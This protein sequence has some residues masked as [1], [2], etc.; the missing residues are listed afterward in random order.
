VSCSD[1]LAIDINNFVPDA[2]SKTRTVRNGV[3]VDFVCSEC[4]DVTRPDDST[5]R[6]PYVLNVGTFEHKKGQDVLVDA[7]ARVAP[8]FPEVDLIIVGR[9]GATR[10]ALLARIKELGLEGRVF[11][12]VDVPHKQTLRFMRDAMVFVLPS[13]AEGLPIAILEAGAL[14][15]PVIASRV[16]GIPEVIDTQDR[17][18]LVA[19]EDGN[20]L[21]EALRTLIKSE[22]LRMRLGHAL[23][24]HVRLNF[25]WRSAWQRYAALLGSAGRLRDPGSTLASPVGRRR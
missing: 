17:G 11:C 6:R 12:R 23:H 2:R 5:I 13:R 25:S 16:D 18:W 7:F 15:I 24:D 10:A 22:G 9:D 20:G 3:D 4:S 14:A 1:A 21:E 8:D 19:P